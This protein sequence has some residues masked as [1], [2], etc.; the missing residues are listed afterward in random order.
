MTKSQYVT[1][2]VEYR[3]YA[4][5]GSALDGWNC[6]VWVTLHLQGLNWT[7]CWLSPNQWY[8]KLCQILMQGHTLKCKNVLH[9]FS[10]SWQSTSLLVK[11]PEEPEFPKSANV[12]DRTML[13]GL[14]SRPQSGLV[15]PYLLHFPVSIPGPISKWSGQWKSAV[16]HMHLIT[17]KPCGAP[18]CFTRCSPWM[19][20]LR[21]Y[22]VY[23][24]DSIFL[25]WPIS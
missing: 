25:V 18:G 6:S 13:T 19:Q 1:Q 11:F 23:R 15:G 8:S 4:D 10:M 7:V 20:V 14:V 12:V 24:S 9:L 22:P 5:P 16:Q 21:T 17:K 2:S 3:V